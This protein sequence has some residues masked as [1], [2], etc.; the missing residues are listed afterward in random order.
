MEKYSIEKLRTMID[1]LTIEET[2]NWLSSLSDNEVQYYKDFIR[3]LEKNPRISQ[4]VR[5]DTYKQHREN[6]EVLRKFY[7]ERFGLDFP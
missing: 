3:E 6:I 2:V 1:S 7:W 5:H 4:A